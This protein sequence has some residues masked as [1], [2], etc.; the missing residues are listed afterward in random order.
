MAPL[1]FLRAID[2]V[3]D[4]EG[5]CGGYCLRFAQATAPYLARQRC[6]GGARS[7]MRQGC[8]FVVQQGDGHIAQ[9]A[10]AAEQRGDHSSSF[11]QVRASLQPKTLLLLW[12]I[13]LE[14]HKDMERSSPARV[15]RGEQLRVYKC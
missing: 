8:P 6:H 7:P 10:E 3:E 1:F 11:T 2:D 4:D 5:R 12:W 14:E 13:D 9:R 15:P